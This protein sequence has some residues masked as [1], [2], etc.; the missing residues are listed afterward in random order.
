MYLLDTNVISEIRKVNLGKANAGVAEWTRQASQSLMYVSVIS[1][2]EIE[3]GIL[4]LQRRDTVQASLLKNWFH[5]TVLPSFDDNVVNIDQR[6]ALACAALH[7]P[8]K[9]PAND[10]L[11]AATA[12]IH[13]LTLVTRNT[14]DFIHTG[15][16]LF[17]PFT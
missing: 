8:D 9:Q 13:D 5:N 15:V 11:I 7:V 2:M 12:L 16:K 14:S 10:S 3:Q 4:R 6:V 1:L 17:N